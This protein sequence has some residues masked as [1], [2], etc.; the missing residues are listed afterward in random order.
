M[1]KSAL[2]FSA[3]LFTYFSLSAIPQQNHL[4]KPK[5]D[6]IRDI[7]NLPKPKA[8]KGHKARRHLQEKQIKQHQK[9]FKKVDSAQKKLN[10]ELQRKD[11]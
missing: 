5:Q 7:K 2:L 10:R 1:K 3:L 6:T 11:N 8:I 4:V 9:Q